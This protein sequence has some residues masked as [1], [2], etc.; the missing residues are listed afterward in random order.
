MSKKYIRCIFRRL[1]RLI[2]R[3]LIS[4]LAAWWFIS[5]RQQVVFQSIIQ[6]V[7]WLPGEI[8]SR[9]RIIM[10]RWMGCKCSDNGVHINIGTLFDDP[11]VEVGNHVFINSFCNISWARIEDYVMIGSGVHVISGKHSHLFDRTDIPIAL[12]GGNFTQVRV[13]YG[14][15]V[16]SRAIIMA[17]VGEECVIGAGAVVTEPIPAWSIAVGIPARVIGSRKPNE[18]MNCVP[19]KEPIYKDGNLAPTIV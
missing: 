3:C 9:T 6:T 7:C 15:W 19:N 17:D 14:T 2:L 13:G 4:P 10:L 1:F 5:G 16:G 11:L 12:Q 18:Q 8:G